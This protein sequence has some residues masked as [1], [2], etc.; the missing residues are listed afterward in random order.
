[1]KET[2]YNLFKR[3]VSARPKA[4]A[5]IDERR[6]LTFRELDELANT[7]S[8]MFPTKT[9]KRVGIMMEHNVEMIASLFAVLKNGAAYIPVEPS[10]PPERIKYIMEEA[11]VDFVITHD[12]YSNLATSF[13]TVLVEQGLRANSSPVLTQ[14]SE[15]HSLAYILYT[16]GTKSKPKGVM[17]DNGNV[18]HYIHAFANEFHPQEGDVMM[19][20]SVCT[21]DIFVEEVFATL[22]NGAALAIPSEETKSDMDRL[23]RFV[24]HN[25]V[26]MISGFPYLLLELNKLKNI[27]SCLRLLISGGDVLRESY[28]TNLIGKVDIYNTYGPSETT[29]CA[30]YFRCNSSQPLPDGT[31]P[32]G[33]AVKGV[34]IEI[35]NDELYPVRDGEVGEICIGGD[36][37]AQGYLGDIPENKNF[38]NTP[39][40]M[41]IYRSGDLAYRLPDGNLAF[42]HRK[43]EQVMIMGKRVEC[44]EVE[45]VLC[46]CNEIECGAV[47]PYVDAQGLSYLVAYII[48]QAKP[49]SLH[50]LKQK[51]SAFLPSFM[52]PEYFV[53]MNSMPLTPN[54]KIDRRALPVI[55]KE[56]NL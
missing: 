34:N 26:S 44:N 6:I 17:V 27:P 28:V 9:P 43:D 33:K 1:M 54:G 16:S 21:F 18:C 48:P 10:F 52:I 56:V 22:L 37:I 32:I 8:G 47:C 3:Q 12:I 41:P 15:P 29:V 30:T 11:H 36:G 50:T 45:N 53:S 14:K 46:A 7:I 19:Q 31:F 20:Y 35:L 25:K 42:L 39:D 24:E 38:T 4:T 49:F 5:V 2:I 55:L 13:S 51:L 40:G 23:M